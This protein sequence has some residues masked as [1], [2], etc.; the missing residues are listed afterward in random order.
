MSDIEFNIKTKVVTKNHVV[1]INAY[2]DG[3]NRPAARA[4]LTGFGDSLQ[5]D[6]SFNDKQ[7]K[8]GL[9]AIKRA[10]SMV[11]EVQA[12]ADRWHAELEGGGDA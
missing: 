9:E 2:F 6:V 3:K 7:L 1:T 8:D 4:R 11:A 5:R 10:Q 12:I